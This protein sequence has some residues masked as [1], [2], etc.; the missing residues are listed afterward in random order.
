MEAAAW[1][2]G[3]S[4]ARCLFACFFCVSCLFKS[5][6]PL[7]LATMHGEKYSCGM[8]L[9]GSSPTNSHK[10]RHCRIK[11][12]RLPACLLVRAEVPVA[13]VAKPGHDVFVFVKLQVDLANHNV[14]TATAPRDTNG[15]MKMS[16]KREAQST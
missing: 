5:F 8:F 12:S 14:H 11:Y 4:G 15:E 13:S 7:Q 2:L 3:S 6:V 1:I 10:H 9:L 16:A